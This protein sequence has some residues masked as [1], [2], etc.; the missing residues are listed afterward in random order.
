MSQPLTLSF[1]TLYSLEGLWDIHTRF[2]TFLQNR[3]ATLLHLYQ[4][5]SSESL[6][7]L[8]PHLEDFLGDLFGVT[9]ELNALFQQETLLKP[10]AQCKRLFVQRHVALKYKE[11]T[12]PLLDPERLRHHLSQWMGEPFEGNEL[13]FATHVLTWLK[14][15]HQEAL[16]DAEDYA[17]WALLT[18]DGQQA[19]ARGTL[20][21]L[22]Q[23]L[24]YDH[25][26]TSVTSIP[27]TTA[28]ASDQAHYCIACHR[29]EKDTCR[30]GFGEKKNPLGEMLKGCPLDQKISEM[31]VLKAQGHVLG[32]L[33]V[34]TIDNPMVAATGHRI[35]NACSK[36]CIFQKQTPVD[37]PSIE[38]HILESILDL[39]WGFEIY[40]L[41]TRWNP[42]KANQV[43]PDSFTGKKVLVAGMGPAGFALSHHMLN[44]GHTVVGIDG[45]RIAPLP[46]ALQEK[47]LIK[48]IK[49][50]FD[51]AD[52]RSPLGFGG[53]AEYGI[54]DRWNKNFLLVLRLLLE[55]RDNFMMLGNTRLE[56]TL[57]TQQAINLGFDHIAL[58]LG[59]GKPNIPSL[60]NNFARGVHQASDFLMGIN[61]K[62]TPISL[63]SPIIVIGSGL[64]AI[65]TAVEALKHSQGD[66]TL[67]YRRSMQE[68]PAYI[69]NHEELAL[70]LAAGVAYLENKT[71]TRIETDDTGHATGVLFK[72]GTRIDART[73][74][75]ATGTRP[76]TIIAEENPVFF[77]KDGDFLKQFSP[78][79]WA[80]SIDSNRFISMLGDLHP[81]YSGSVVHALASAKKASPLIT[82]ALSRHAPASSLS[83]QDFFATIKD[84]FLARVLKKEGQ[85]LTVYAPL[86]SQNLKPGQFFRLDDGGKT[87]PLMGTL[88][89]GTI[90]L[91]LRNPSLLSSIQEGDVLAL[92]GPTG[93]PM[94]IPRNKKV[95][96][97]GH[98]KALTF[99]GTAME[100]KGCTVAYNAAL[101]Q[102]WD[103]IFVLGS[104]DMMEDLLQHRSS[105][106]DTI[107]ISGILP[108]PMQCMMKGI[109][110][111][112]IQRHVDPITGHEHFV[113][114]C[115]KQIH[116]LEEVD[117]QMLCGRMGC[118]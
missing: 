94:E 5:H 76:N 37:V 105:L 39:P 14:A 8:A 6:I 102:E 3:D 54:T 29:Q 98:G 27:E 36:A 11:K 45:L 71:P 63:V 16:Q 15:D 65:D 62:K 43:L 18:E 60:A 50:F 84:L 10:I 115:E 74:F 114:S 57:T 51:P 72:D 42:L 33:A 30:K 26:I 58:C 35:C 77:E 117:F 59:A 1:D 55:R 118:V 64:T 107:K 111:K 86:A 34:I 83:R 49:D 75:L 82:E 85:S 22:P 92:M 38:T 99:I 40:S 28:W 97:M 53:V 89:N 93:S 88:E 103:E 110:G 13:M 81:E 108:T 95:L 17:A 12:V 32:A 68:S 112:C 90:V 70:T 101:S 87:M 41:L 47:T 78:P 73:I 9:K 61:L 56:S 20:F 67:V 4:T 48:Y 104:V 109:C 106:K 25:L 46:N 21:K 19:H 52:T 100:Q 91:T 23:K 113:F 96:L 2:L 69:K 66:V 80:G 44:D 31:N 79:F 116:P 24:D 7:A